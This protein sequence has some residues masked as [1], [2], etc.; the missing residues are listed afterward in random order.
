VR[1]IQALIA[2]AR[3]TLG[4]AAQEVSPYPLGTQ[5]T[6]PGTCDRLD[7]RGEPFLCPVMPAWNG[8]KAEVD[9]LVN[10]LPAPARLFDLQLGAQRKEDR[11]SASPARAAVDLLARSGRHEQQRTVCRKAS[12]VVSDQRRRGADP[13]QQLLF[14]LPATRPGDGHGQRHALQSNRLDAQIADAAYGSPPRLEAL[15]TPGGSPAA[16]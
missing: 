7:V 12:E 13:I 5:V 9:Q 11:S 15:N 1:P 4:Q 8:G 14:A 6:C 3:K 10:E 2:L 16:K